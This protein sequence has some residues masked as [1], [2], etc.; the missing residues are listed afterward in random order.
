M[1]IQYLHITIDKGAGTKI[2]A[3]VPFYEYAILS[4]AHNTDTDEGTIE[5]VHV[6]ESKAEQGREIRALP[7]EFDV[8]DEYSRLLAAYGKGENARFIR[9]LWRDE[10]AF[11]TAIEKNALGCEKDIKA[12]VPV[13][14]AAPI[15]LV[16]PEIKRSRR[17][18]RLAVGD[19]TGRVRVAKPD[20]DA[21]VKTKPKAA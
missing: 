7:E 10:E 11:E 12:G 9:R 18:S 8:D 13:S 19:D 4:E 14:E 21:I 20:S 3:I 1:H 2:P 16:N 5:N 17:R 15:M 6:D